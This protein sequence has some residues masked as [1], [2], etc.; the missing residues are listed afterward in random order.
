MSHQRN[1]T[2]VKLINQTT[3][4][5]DMVGEAIVVIIRFV[6]Q[7]ASKMIHRYNTT[8]DTQARD[9]SSPIKRPSR[10]AMHHQNGIRILIETTLVHKMELMVTY[11]KKA[12]SEWILTSPRLISDAGFTMNR[13]GM[14]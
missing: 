10:I 7:T 4:V 9:Q 11:R 8:M 13:L 1:V 3:Q 2:E 5:L 14:L 6:T 12:R